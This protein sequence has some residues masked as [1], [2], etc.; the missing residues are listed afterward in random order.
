MLREPSGRGP[1]REA[2]TLVMATEVTFRGRAL[3]LRSDD[4]GYLPAE[5]A[6]GQALL[7]HSN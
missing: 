5:I 3:R 7:D 2:R 6:I 4:G 1:K